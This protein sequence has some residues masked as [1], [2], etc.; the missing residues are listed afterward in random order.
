M[1]CLAVHLIPSLP[2]M[3][4]FQVDMGRARPGR[5][6]SSVELNAINDI[7]VRHDAIL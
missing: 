3:A 6:A 5:G 7:D 2:T 4:M 1:H